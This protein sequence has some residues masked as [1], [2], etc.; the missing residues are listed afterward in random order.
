MA[1]TR[2]FYDLPLTAIPPSP[3]LLAW[4]SVL[5]VQKTNCKQAQTCSALEYGASETSLG[6]DGESVFGSE[7][8]CEGSI[9]S[10]FLRRVFKDQLTFPDQLYSSLSQCVRRNKLT[11]GMLCHLL[12]FRSHVYGFC[13]FSTYFLLI[14][15]L[16]ST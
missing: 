1:R 12:F 7:Q 5:N 14:F 6:L 4:A 8:S 10:A 13:L 15:C 11:F 16:F 9:S 3:L 2:F